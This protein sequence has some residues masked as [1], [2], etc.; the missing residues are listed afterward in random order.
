M[1]RP[2]GATP[3]HVWVY[4][5]RLYRLDFPKEELAVI[6]EDVLERR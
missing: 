3:I 5:G 6:R 2:E 1:Q 4:N